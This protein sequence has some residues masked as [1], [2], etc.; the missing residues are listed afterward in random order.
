[1]YHNSRIFKE[2]YQPRPFCYAI[3]RPD[4]SPEGVVAVEAALSDGSMAQPV[5]TMV[6]TSRLETA[7]QFAIAASARVAFRGEVHVHGLMMHEFGGDSGVKLTLNARARQFSSFLVLVGRIAGPGLFDPQYGMICQNKDEITIP[8]EVETIPSA[9]EL[10]GGDDI[11]FA[12]AAGVC[13]NVSGDAVR[14]D[15]VWSVRDSDQAAAGEAAE[16]DRGRA[17]KR[18]SAD[19]RSAGAV[20]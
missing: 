7:M 9:G 20:Y 4:H 17:D 19:A 10:E 12:G 3:R 6:A 15:A 5:A 18:D 13:E 11:D 16:S 1:M 8:L 2:E 14:V